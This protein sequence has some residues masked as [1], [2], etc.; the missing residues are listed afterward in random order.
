MKKERQQAV[1]KKEVLTELE[2]LG[3]QKIDVLEDEVAELQGEL[4]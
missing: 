1:K 4:E 2:K 3:D